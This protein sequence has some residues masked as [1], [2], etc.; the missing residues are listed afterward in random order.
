VLPSPAELLDRV[1]YGRSRADELAQL[2]ARF[3]AL[4][5]LPRGGQ[6]AVELALELRALRER[7]HAELGRVA[8]C[9]G[10]ARGH[11]APSGRWDGGH[12]CGGHTLELFSQDEV[13]ALWL[14]GT[15]LRHL[16][17]PSA[18]HAGCTFRGPAGCSLAPAHRPTICVRYLCLSLREELRQR[19]DWSTM[20]PLSA[21]MARL[22]GELTALRVAADELPPELAL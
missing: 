10:C 14:A 20:A 1:R 11:P 2:R 4:S 16:T 19:G 13:A 8:S 17:P 18:D 6:R 3:R 5:A 9:A 7:A 12:C 21:A 15:R 22:F